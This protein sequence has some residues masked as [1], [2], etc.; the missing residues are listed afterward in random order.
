MLLSISSTSTVMHDP[1]LVADLTISARLLCPGL[2]P[3]PAPDPRG[4][5]AG[6]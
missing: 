4:E 3:A 6:G 5:G 1:N 2:R